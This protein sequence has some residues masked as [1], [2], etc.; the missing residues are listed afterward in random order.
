MWECICML[1]HRA[2]GSFVSM[3]MLS[4]YLKSTGSGSIS[5]QGN[6]LL[7][8]CRQMDLTVG[9]RPSQYDHTHTRAHA[10]VSFNTAI[11]FHC[12]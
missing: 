12:A 6:R 5:F 4:S 2:S 11:S 3:C 8:L 9:I 10:L 1:S 7:L